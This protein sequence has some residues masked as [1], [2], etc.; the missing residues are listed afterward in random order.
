MQM[1][2][3]EEDDIIIIHMK[4]KILSNFPGLIYLLFFNDNVVLI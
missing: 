4:D 1:P 3:F 2:F